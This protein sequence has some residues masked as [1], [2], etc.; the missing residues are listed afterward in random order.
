MSEKPYMPIVRY[1]NAESKRITRECMESALILLLE[2]KTFAEISVSELVKRAGVSRTAFYRNYQSKEEV[3]QSALGD[4]VNAILNK[5][6]LNSGS[7]AFW[8]VLFCEVKEYCHSIRL[9]LKA[10][11]GNTILEE[12]TA[13]AVTKEDSAVPLPD[14]ARSFGPV[15]F[16]MF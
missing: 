15:R 14:I 8:N 13:R 2:N 7:E 6:A 16:I 4:V 11:L 12:I 5:L 10:G 1:S 3:L 9:L